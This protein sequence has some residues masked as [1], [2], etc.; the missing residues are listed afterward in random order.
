MM[1]S[2]SR[3]CLTACDAADIP[4]VATH[5]ETLGVATNTIQAIYGAGGMLNIVLQGKHIS[6]NY[7][8][9]NNMEE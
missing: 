6:H 8:R 5:S 4:H 1:A 3:D 2:A 7:M 9:R